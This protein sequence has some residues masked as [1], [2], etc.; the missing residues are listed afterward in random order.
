MGAQIGSRSFSLDSLN[1]LGNESTASNPREELRQIFRQQRNP[2]VVDE[3]G[4]DGEVVM[5]NVANIKKKPF[6]S[7]KSNNA[8]VE[9][10][11]ECSLSDLQAFAIQSNVPVIYFFHASWCSHCVKLEPIL[12]EKINEYAGA[13]KL[14]MID[15]D[16]FDASLLKELSFKGYPALLGSINGKIVSS[17]VGAPP[18]EA[19]DSFL[20]SLLDCHITHSEDSFIRIDAML[21]T[22]SQNSHSLDQMNLMTKSILLAAGNLANASF[23]K[24]S[25][26]SLFFI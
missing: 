23:S 2:S 16:N 8:S 15:V 14:A 18:S 6:S 9:I 22:F 5:K 11:R 19:L 25:S 1:S 21:S 10:V 26:S 20:E 3:E 24:L 7:G 17:C 4:V 12:K 13:V